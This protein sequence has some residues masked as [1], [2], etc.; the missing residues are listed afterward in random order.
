M[1]LV[2][3]FHLANPGADFAN[4]V[5]DD[6]LAPARQDEMI[7]VVNGLARFAP[8]RVA[9]EAAWDDPRAQSTYERYRRGE[10]S[11]GRSETEQI[12]FR[13]A[14]ACEHDRV[15]PVDVMDDFYIPEIEELL[16]ESRHAQTWQRLTDLAQAAAATETE[17]LRTS[18]IGDALR[19]LNTEATRKAML[20][21]YLE[22]ATIAGG[23]NWS[24]PDMAAGWYRRNFRIAAN[25]YQLMAP[26]E[27][28][29][30]IYGAG[31][32]PVLEQVLT[33]Q[34]VT[35]VDPLDFLDR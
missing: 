27:R 9:V 3:T 4:V 32:V 16:K 31:H 11:L 26:D 24:G 22:I 25:L 8:T 18:T 12:G 33:G 1:L 21:P 2:G 7:R 17:G 20:Q 35:V 5:V 30:V 6:V 10:V 13:L 19:S 28:I 15:Y 23:G 34:G 29:A 14:A